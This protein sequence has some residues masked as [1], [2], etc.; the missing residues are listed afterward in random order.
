[1]KRLL[2]TMPGPSCPFRCRYC[3]AEFRQYKPQKHL[4]DVA[5]N[6]ALLDDVEIVY[7]ACDNDLLAF[8]HG[9][10]YLKR[11]AEFGRSISFS[12]KAAIT[13]TTA[14]ELAAVS[15]VLEA[16][17]AVLK[18]GISFSTL[19]IPSFE[20]GTCSYAR[21]LENLQT[22]QKFGIAHC[23]ILKPILAQC[24]TPQYEAIVHDC[25]DSTDLLLVGDEYLDDEDSRNAEG[26][27]YREVNWLAGTPKWPVRESPE[28]KRE[29]VLYAKTMNFEVFESD[30]TLMK[31]LVTS[32]FTTQ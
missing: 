6:P 14:K 8:S 22:L 31:Y 5:L 17:G 2:L 3:F 7:P 4:E 12:T 25:C 1:M 16:S 23:V 24:S 15:R 20:P 13:E 11:V 29:I 10:D 27:N 30:L 18:V 19:D 21:R 9:I 26:V 28:K 32:A